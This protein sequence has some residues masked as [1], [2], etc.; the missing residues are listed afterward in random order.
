MDE[1][2]HPHYV[3]KGWKRNRN[4]DDLA[5]PS[6]IVDDMSVVSAVAPASAEHRKDKPRNGNCVRLERHEP[7]RMRS[8]QNISVPGLVDDLSNAAIIPVPNFV[9]KA[10]AVDVGK[11]SLMS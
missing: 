7:L 9:T 5:K 8:R 11:R 2:R 4:A 1:Y 3:T 6:L 10:H